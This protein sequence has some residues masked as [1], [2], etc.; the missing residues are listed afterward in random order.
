MRQ[1]HSSMSAVAFQ[2][3][4]TELHEIFE[5]YRLVIEII[6]SAASRTQGTYQPSNSHGDRTEG[7]LTG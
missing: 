3:A 4:S 5:A 1:D 2:I 6:T 7:V